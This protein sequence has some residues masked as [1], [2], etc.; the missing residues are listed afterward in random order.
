[1]T[2]LEREVLADQARDIGNPRVMIAKGRERRRLPTVA[3]AAAWM[4]GGI[5]RWN[6]PG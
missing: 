3:D 6:A 4:E 5:K 2:R 1:M